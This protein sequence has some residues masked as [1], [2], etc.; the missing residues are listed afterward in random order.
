[1][2]LMGQIFL[3]FGTEVKTLQKSHG[4]MVMLW[5]VCVFEDSRDDRD[6]WSKLKAI[7]QAARYDL[8]V[9]LST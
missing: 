9:S 3:T 4:H 6:S 5:C 1:M 8:M 7:C 2:K